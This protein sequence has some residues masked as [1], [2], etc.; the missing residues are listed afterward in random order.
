[1]WQNKFFMK[2]TN[3]T[4]KQ[5]ANL[6]EGLSKTEQFIEDNSKILFS[7]IGGLILVFIAYYGYNNLYKG[8]L[9][10]K[11]QKHLFIAEQY[12]E[13]DSFQT[14][15]EGSDKFDGLI[16]ISEQYSNTK[17]G[18]LAKYYAGI[19]YLNIGEYE[20]AIKIL[21]EYRSDDL[22]LLSIAQ[23]AIGD[24]FAQI[25]QTSEAIDYYQKAIQIET[26]LLTTPIT[27]M[28]CAQLYELE[29]DYNNAIK[30]YKTI[31]TDYPDSKI[32]KSIDKYIG[33]LQYHN[34]DQ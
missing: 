3:S 18:Q 29:E 20:N 27:L 11:A 2:K 12:F 21:D 26:N 10:K 9:N 30:C 17:S 28:K 31:K 5:L 14:A 15:L 16:S 8:P 13:K 34:S 32:A 33:N 1:M 24:A 19:S 6:E 23:I 4:E 25:N 7:I 22:L